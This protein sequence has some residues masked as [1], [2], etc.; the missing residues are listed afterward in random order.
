MLCSTQRIKP[1]LPLFFL[2]LIFLVFSSYPQTVNAEVWGHWGDLITRESGEIDLVEKDKNSLEKILGE[3]LELF[4]ETAPLNPP[5]QVQVRPIAYLEPKLPLLD[6][7][8]PARGY[9]DLGMVFPNQGPPGPSGRI[10]VWLNE[11][12]ALLG[13]PLAFAEE[14]YPIY[15]LPPVIEDK[16]SG[17]L[18]S[19]SAHP[20]GYEEA[21]PSYSFFPLWGWE[22]ETFLREVIQPSF[23]LAESS[24]LTILTRGNKPFWE[25]VSQEEW[26]TSL[27][28]YAQNEIDLF[29]AG[30]ETEKKEDF[31]QDQ[32]DL[33][34]KRLQN[35]RKKTSPENIIE[36]HENLMQGIEQAIEFAEFNLE[37]AQTEEQEEHWKEMLEKHHENLE[38]QKENLDEQIKNFQD[39]ANQVLE[40][41]EQLIKAQIYQGKLKEKLIPLISV[42]N[43]AAIEKKGEEID[44][45]Y[46]IFLGRTGQSRDEL[47]KELASLS[48]AERNAP[49][50]G[51]D[52]P[53]LHPLGSHRHVV[54]MDHD[55]ERPS[56]LVPPETKGS[57]A[58]V[59]LKTDF[60]DTKLPPDSIQLIIVRWWERTDASH[61]STSG[62]YYHQG[63][64]TMM[65]NL[66]KHLDWKQL[67]QILH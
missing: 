30:M 35:L 23:N 14:G 65:E 7:S 44:S 3:I 52:I 66:W 50:Y 49:A 42:E 41:G 5:Q 6:Q 22:V 12:E 24:V 2:F 37:K 25:P 32:I 16:A 9:I 63:R 33:L 60:F 62:R 26:I 34:E 54:A 61:F 39:M 47:E 46:L 31:H 38:T 19:R 27:M 36:T 55:A 43:W 53:P 20:V 45:P 29:L 4:K 64:R 40:F 51:F 28:D 1:W 48:P 56:G 13:T 8:G 59:R 57:R 15:L 21:F 58:L 67:H 11:P 10:Q 17:P 18:F